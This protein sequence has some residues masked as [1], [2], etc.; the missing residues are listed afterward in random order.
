[1]WNVPTLHGDLLG[2]TVRLHLMDG[3]HKHRLVRLV[4][5]LLEHWQ[6]AH[7]PPGLTQLL[8]RLL[9]LEIPARETRTT[10]TPGPATCT[11]PATE[12]TVTQKE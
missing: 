6:S 2:S 4:K 11:A 7:V 10:T 8:S 3:F 9:V 12:V 5:V 1:M